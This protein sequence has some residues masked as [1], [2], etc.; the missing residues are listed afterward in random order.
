MRENQTVSVVGPRENVLNAWIQSNAVKVQKGFHLVIFFCVFVNMQPHHVVG[1][2][3]YCHVLEYRV[4]LQNT[5]AFIRHLYGD[6]SHLRASNT[7]H[8]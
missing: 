1:H 4:H 2:L 6:T 7:V 8:V 3:R 5:V